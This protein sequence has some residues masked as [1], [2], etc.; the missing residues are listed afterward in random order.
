MSFT[1]STNTAS[2]KSFSSEEATNT[3]CTRSSSAHSIFI[4]CL[5]Q[6][7]SRENLLSHFSLYGEV[8]RLDIERKTSSDA[9]STLINAYLECESEQMMENILNNP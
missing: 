3:A 5:P 7:I 6:R 8:T 9:S 1:K 4:G 2:T